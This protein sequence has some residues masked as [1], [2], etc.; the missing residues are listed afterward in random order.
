MPGMSRCPNPD[1]FGISPLFA[2]SCTDCVVADLSIFDLL[3]SPHEDAV[4]P[5]AAFQQQIWSFRDWQA[6]FLQGADEAADHWVFRGR[7]PRNPGDCGV[8]AW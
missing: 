1:Y 2:S 3:G 4:Y 6:G 7:C 8:Y 5:A